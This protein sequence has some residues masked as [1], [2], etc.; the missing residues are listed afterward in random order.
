[1][2][3]VMKP[4]LPNIHEVQKYIAIIDANRIYSN[5]GP[6][7]K[8][9]EERLATFL[10]VDA[11]RLVCLNNA[12]LA[13][14]GCL[15]RLMKTNVILPSYTFAASALSAQFAGTKVCFVD[16][17]VETGCIDL[18]LVKRA[19][20]IEVDSIVMPVS[21][22]GAP[23][24]LDMYEDFEYVIIDA[25][26]SMGSLSCNLMDLKEN[27]FV[28]FSLHATKVFGCGE[29]AVVICGSEDNAN[30]LR[31]WSNF[32][33]SGNRYPT[34]VGINAK[35]S[36]IMAAYGL[37]VLDQSDV[38]LNE[39]SSLLNKIRSASYPQRYRSGLENMPGIRPYWL[40]NC[41]SSNERE[42]L[43]KFLAEN[44]VDSRRWWPRALHT[45]S[46]FENSPFFH[47]NYKG[48]SSS[49][50][51]AASQLGLPFF[52]DLSDD[53]ISKIINLLNHFEE[54]RSDF[55]VG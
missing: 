33:F 7:L 18:R 21:A 47:D 4:R 35:L 27:W 1:M 42:S 29:G 41:S 52:R 54:M 12:T 9:Y 16:V 49:E 10:N 2:I 44:G 24:T 11:K 8:L 48:S 50:H 43:E 40:V 14:A 3:P 6:L 37:A 55:R 20:Q 39:W 19:M 5:N 30:W 28:V 34:Q 25:A 23:V 53:Q 13:L 31:S 26:A 15:K 17:E 32:G 38:E 22:F 46:I 51:L 36:E 45:L